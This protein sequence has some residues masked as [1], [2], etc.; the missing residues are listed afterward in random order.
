MMGIASGNGL[1]QRR[2][3]RG[4]KCG[5]VPQGDGW[6]VGVVIGVHGPGVTARAL[7]EKPESRVDV[8]SRVQE[9]RLPGEKNS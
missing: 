9:A 7:A 4:N 3:Y 5:T 6:V 8:A 1:S 2:V